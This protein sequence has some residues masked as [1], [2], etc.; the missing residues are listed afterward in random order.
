MVATV[1]EAKA[2]VA[3]LREHNVGRA[4][5]VILEKIAHMGS[6]AAAA[7]AGPKGVE[8]LFDLITPDVRQCMQA[9]G[10]TR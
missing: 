3:F 2:C 6:K 10:N 5:F 7:F 1:A 4:T 9:P 8:R